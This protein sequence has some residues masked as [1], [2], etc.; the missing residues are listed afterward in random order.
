MPNAT[1]SIYFDHIINT[2][3][4]RKRVILKFVSSLM[5]VLLEIVIYACYQSS[6]YVAA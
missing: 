3:Y 6:T 5:Y 2:G 1:R 4:F